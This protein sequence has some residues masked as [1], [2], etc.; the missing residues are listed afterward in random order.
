M[1][2]KDPVGKLDPSPATYTWTITAH[3]AQIL[4]VKP[5]ATGTGDCA[6][7][8]NACSLQDALGRAVSNDELWVTGGRY[9][10]GL[11][12]NATF[13]LKS[14][15][16]VYGGFAGTESAR[17]QRNP[18]ANLSVLSGDID[19]N[20]SQTPVITDLKTV[21]G[22]ITNSY[23]VVTGRNGAILD[24]FTITAGNANGSNLTDQIRG[25]GMYNVG[26]SPALT[27]ISFR[28]NSAIRGGGMDN[29]A[30]SNPTLAN[31]IFSGNSATYGGG[32]DNDYFSSPRLTYITFS[33][34][35]AT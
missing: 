6:S 35:S 16:A 11:E 34:N 17:A 29:Y 1:R 21:S 32:M 26:S 9:T 15:V 20:D 22:N 12:R 14:G 24:G 28:G 5:S 8:E 13:Q 4:H 31:V 18:A 23:H 10:P 2:A 25:G 33:A 30:N 27:N 19:N 3:T 7:W